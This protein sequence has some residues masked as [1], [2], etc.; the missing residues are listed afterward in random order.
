MESRMN[1]RRMCGK[2]AVVVLICAAAGAIASAQSVQAGGKPQI[3]NA[4]VEQREV[5]TGVAQEV[6]AWAATVEEAQWLGYSVAAVNGDHRMCCGDSGGDWNGGRACGR[7][8]L[9]GIKSGNSYNLQGGNVKLEGRG[10]LMVL[11]RAEGGKIGKIR[12][13]SEEHGLHAAGLHVPW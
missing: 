4:K 13:L 3:T 10:N 1:W 12:A 2:L 9:E 7:C 11:F 8:R 5:R 6:N